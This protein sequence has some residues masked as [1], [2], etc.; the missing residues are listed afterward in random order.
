[1][2]FCVKAQGMRLNF[3]FLMLVAG[4]ALGQAASA[5]E[6]LVHTFLESRPFQGLDMELD[7]RRIG[8]T[9]AQGQVSTDLSAGAHTL[10]A[11]RNAAELAV[12]DFIVEAGESAEISLTFSD[13]QSAPEITIATFDSS[14]PGGPSGRIVG[15]VADIN[16]RPIADALIRAPQAGV[17]VR[18]KPDGSYSL[19]LPRGV[20]SLEI[21]HPDFN[22]VSKDD[23]RVVANIGI[24]ANIMMLRPLSEGSTAGADMDFSDVEEV[25]VM[26]A[27]KPGEDTADLEKFSV[28]ITD[29][30]SIDDL[31]RF[32]D[33]DV[34]AA[35]KRIV[36]VAVTGGKYAN[37]RGLDGRYISS[38][39]NGSL[40]PSTDPFRR[41]V[42]LDLFP[43]EIL[44][45]IEIQK[46]FTADLPGDT[47]GGII[48]MTSRELPEENEFGLSVSLG[49]VD[50]AT[51]EDLLSYEGS[52]A[53]MFGFDDGLREL[54]GGIRANLSNG[55]FRFSICQFDG[56]SNCIAQEQGAALA[57]QLPNVY[58]TTRESAGPDFG[59]A[60]KLGRR[61]E[62]ETGDFAFYS[63][64]TYDQ[65]YASRQDA[66]F[67]DTDAVG[68]YDWDSFAVSLNGYLVAG[69]VSD[70]G[71]DV[72]S[73]TIILRDSEDRAT[74][75]VGFN[76]KDEVDETLTVLEWVERQFLGQQIDGSISLFGNH[77]LRLRAGLSQTNRLSPDRREY[78]YRNNVFIASTLERS[79]S[80]LTEDGLDLGLDY[81]MPLQI[82]DWL[83]TNLK[84][85]VLSNTRDRDNELIR[86]G[87]L[88]RSGNDLDPSQDLE[89][90]LVAENF[91]NDLYRLNT[92]KTTDTDSYAASQDT[93]ALY[94]SAETDLGSDLTVVTGVRLEDY[95]IDLNYPNASDDAVSADSDRDSS[96]TLPSLSVIYR[97]NDA[98]QVRGGFA[99][100]VSRPNITELAASRF[101]DQE[102]RQ[103]IGC[104]NCSDSDIS[105]F[106]L[107]GEYYF[108]D[109][110][111]VSLA[112]FY[113][114]IS[115][116]L[117]RAVSDGSGSAVSALTFR[118]SE[119]ATVQGVELD[120]STRVLDGIDHVIDLSGNIAVIE[121]DISLDADGQRL[122]GRDSREL[123]GQ[124][125]FLANLQVAYDNYAWDAKLTFV[126]NYFDDRIDAVARA[127]QEP[128]KE[129]GRLDINVTAEKT[130]R[131]GS[132]FS[133]KLKNLLDEPIE[134]TQGGRVIETYKKGMS[135]SLGYS[136][137]F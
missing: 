53:D 29:A 131:N 48:R 81:E 36:G 4:L 132:K 22:T 23:M 91:E 18:S 100:T 78:Q 15:L 106:D 126:A 84:F 121:S 103:Y 94:L 25:M 2:R 8:R 57:A 32:G 46:S 61:Y 14:A 93:T 64:L 114:D 12:Y 128:I 20:H 54:P 113:K 98:L 50:G 41:D 135:L 39:L 127:P 58:N 31:L 105:N 77:E 33:S 72:L 82:N 71:W 40:M 97:L 92:N 70:N 68:T 85:G 107:R 3:R 110:D 26:G 134:R 19:E 86:L 37:V 47:T 120:A 116:P 69:W 27:Y 108:G 95:S 16:D 44:G 80:D 1:M 35:L 49:Y 136:L 83:F 67:N 45:G 88:T 56:Q 112:L 137:S 10:R 118:N 13:F 133:L 75:E 87:V 125:P 79:Y 124:S 38:T 43:A 7:E 129:S 99:R 66:S 123:Q 111:S 104:P 6:L 122:E 102:G 34:A 130:L 76:K 9:G 52:D 119:S 109:Q 42:Q 73:K 5:Q 51:G 11:L 96:E 89:T 115:D 59:L 65:G 117:E 21:S 30:I 17:E 62:R 101:F 74:Y 60:A 24:A 55:N 90:L 28:A 63:S